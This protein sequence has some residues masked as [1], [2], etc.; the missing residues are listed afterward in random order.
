MLHHLTSSQVNALDCVRAGPLRPCGPANAL[1]LL[2]TSVTLSSLTGCWRFPAVP[3]RPTIFTRVLNAT[4]VQ[5]AWEL[6]SKA[7]KAEGFRL[8]YRRVPHAT[9]QGPVQ[10]PF[11]VNTYTVTHLG[12]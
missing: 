11:H 5:V 3:A 9:F 4:S 12:V 7:G 10:L 2:G 1:E 8:S 6:P